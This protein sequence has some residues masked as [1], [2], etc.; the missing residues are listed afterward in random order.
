MEKKIMLNT[1]HRIFRIGT[2]RQTHVPIY[3][4][5]DIYM[6]IY[7]SKASPISQLVCLARYTKKVYLVYQK[8]V[9]MIVMSYCLTL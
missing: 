1:K 9:F 7:I 2:K 3:V 6:N 8:F 4:Y 5:I